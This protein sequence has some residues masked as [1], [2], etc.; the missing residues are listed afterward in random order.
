[1]A[2]KRRSHITQLV[3]VD[4]IQVEVVCKD[5]KHIHLRVYPPDGRVRVSV[6][7]RVDEAT[8]RCLV[9]ARS[10]WIRLQQARVVREA[11]QEERQFL[12]GETH[13][14]EGQAYR[15]RVIEGEGPASVGLQGG[16]ME[17]RVRP[18][19]DEDK[20]RA[21]LEAWYRNSLKE[22]LPPLLAH[23]EPKIGVQVA[24]CRIK[25]MKTRWG[26]CNTTARRIWLNLE[27]AKKRPALLEGILVHEMV[28]LLER[29]H[30][31]RFEE[32]MDRFLPD[33]RARRAELDRS[34]RHG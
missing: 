21:V 20:R 19:S 31:E 30:N 15:L 32:L 12:T 3:E 28:H 2:K 13:W 8:V 17:L 23:W 24:E 25:R 9:A 14:F 4:G 29:W 27:L 22:K 10:E 11:L 33:W 5:I 6:P 26:S 16:T 18:G 7:R 1:M 34:A